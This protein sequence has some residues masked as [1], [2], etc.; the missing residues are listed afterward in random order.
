MQITSNYRL[1]SHTLVLQNFIKSHRMKSSS[2]PSN[3]V[4]NSTTH[5][6]VEKCVITIFNFTTARCMKGARLKKSMRAKNKKKLSFSSHSTGIRSPQIA[7]E[8]FYL[9]VSRPEVSSFF[10]SS[11]RI[12]FEEMRAKKKQCAQ[13]KT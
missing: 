4:M 12:P 3:V 7:M 1:Y 5:F 2:T 11:L 6:A 13:K 10:S 9:L 8:I